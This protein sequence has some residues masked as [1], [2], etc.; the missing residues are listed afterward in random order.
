VPGAENIY[1]RPG[2]TVLFL[3]EEAYWDGPN[4]NL[5][6][7]RRFACEPWTSPGNKY[8]VVMD[9]GKGTCH[10]EKV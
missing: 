9:Q 1:K 7:Q 10:V 4:G 3:N 8:K 5:K 6:F 2:S